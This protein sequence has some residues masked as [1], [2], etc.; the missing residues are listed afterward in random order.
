M[1]HIAIDKRH[2][3]D[4]IRTLAHELVHYKQDLE[5]QLGHHSGKTGSPAENQAHALAGIMMRFFNKKHPEFLRS[6]SIKLP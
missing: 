6:N 4:I 5:Q 2:P 3:N 1:L